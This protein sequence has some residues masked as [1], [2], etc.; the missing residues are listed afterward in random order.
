M[1]VTLHPES[2]AERSVLHVGVRVHPYCD[3]VAPRHTTAAQRRHR[4][5]FHGYRTLN[6]PS[7]I[8]AATSVATIVAVGALGFF[9]EKSLP[10]APRGLGCRMNQC[11]RPLSDNRGQGT[12]ACATPVALRC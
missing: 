11:H 9:V 5:T 12:A 1:I 2:F 6:R 8:T 10:R 3:L 4:G 7:D